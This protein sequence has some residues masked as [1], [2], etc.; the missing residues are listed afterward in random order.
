MAALKQ[1]IF[2]CHL[3]RV[4]PGVMNEKTCAGLTQTIAETLIFR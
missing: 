3:E 2:V 4:S 1:R